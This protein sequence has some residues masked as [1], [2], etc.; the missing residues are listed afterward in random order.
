MSVREQ[1]RGEDRTRFEQKDKDVG[2]LGQQIESLHRL[3][4]DLAANFKLSQRFNE[5]TIARKTK[6]LEAVLREKRCSSCSLCRDGVT[7]KNQDL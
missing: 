7:S 4:R 1:L 5:E 2:K 6:E 3:N